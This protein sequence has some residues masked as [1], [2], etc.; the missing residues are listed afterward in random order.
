MK[1]FLIY[2]SSA[3]SGKTY[4]LVK[5]YLKLVLANP[6]DFRHTLAITFTNKAA[7]EM[8]SR[9]IE[10]LS[11]LADG[12]N[13][14]LKKTLTS[15]GVKCN[16]KLTS[17]DVLSRILH[18]Y[19]DFSVST[20]DSFFQKVIRSFAKELKLHL[21][22]TI[23]LDTD[24]VLDKVIDEIFTLIG[25]DAELTK[26][27][28]EFTFQSMDED[29]GW[30]VEK[31]IK[32][33]SG[34]ILKERYWQKKEQAADDIID[35]RNRIKEFI[36]LLKSF[37]YKFENYL[38]K[39][40]NNA[41]EIIKKH[42]LE[43]ED[44]KR[45]NTSIAA[46]FKKLTEKTNYLKASDIKPYEI[47]YK[48]I[49]GSNEWYTKDS[50]KKSVIQAAVDDGLEK[51]LFDIVRYYDSNIKKYISVRI[52]LKTIYTVGIFSDVIEKLKEY[53]D[54]NHVLLISDAGNLLKS[55]INED[56]SPFVYE[57][58]G[59]YYKHYL[60]DEFQ[61][62]STFQ[63]HS[64]LPLVLN[65]LSEQ[66]FSMVVGDVKQS[67]YRWRNG[68]MML[69]LKDIEKDLAHYKELIESKPLDTN[70]R[71]RSNIIEFNNNLFEQAPSLIAGSIESDEANIIT[72][73]YKEANQKAKP[74]HT[75]GYV[76]AE[77]VQ[78][79]KDSDTGTNEIAGNKMIEII[80]KLKDECVNPGDILILARS[81]DEI[82]NIAAL[83]TNA[84]YKVVS[85]ESLL[86]INSPKVKL[87][88]SLFK[89]I[90]DK[91]NRLAIT[92]ALYNYIIINDQN[93]SSDDVFGK[94]E[95]DN[96]LFY[97]LMP[98]EL[99]SR[100]GEKS[101]PKINPNL[102]RQNLYELTESLI[103]IFGLNKKPDLYLTRFLDVIFE[104]TLKYNQDINAFNN[105]WDDNYTKYSISVTGQ[106]DAIK[107]MT[108]HKAKGLESPVVIIPFTSW[109]T[110]LSGNRDNIWVSSNTI[111]FD[112][113][114][115]YLVKAVK[116][117]KESYFADDY[118]FE[119]VMTKLDNLNL[120]YVAF[121][122]A[123]DRLYIISPQKAN[124]SNN[125]N[126]LLAALFENNEWF[127][128]HKTGECIYEF[129]EP[130]K[131]P[132]EKED[133]ETETLKSETL[134][135]VNFHNKIVIK[136]I[137]E[138]I[139]FERA[140]NFYKAYNRGLILHKALSYIKSAADINRS[141]E[142]IKELGLITDNQDEDL[143]AEL[144]KIVT[145]KRIAGWFD[146][147]SE[148]K[149]EQEIIT[150]EGIFRPDRIIIKGSK[151]T[152]VDY[153]T[154]KELTEHKSQMKKYSEIIKHMGYREIESY[155]FY[156]GDL[157]IVRVD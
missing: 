57:K 68:N 150:D 54:E 29:K 139:S 151:I 127:K 70:Y 78:Y 48:I 91:K 7:E 134:T 123:R 137:H 64:L 95:I 77:F 142:K 58:I 83:V 87:L 75:G 156:L 138:N 118:D 62:T 52:L 40:A 41:L 6:E 155:L 17:A 132:S 148:I 34:E 107:V 130:V 101:T 66:N 136:P 97:K 141:A 115:S 105:W 122:R 89:F 25:E 16:I 53:R 38:I 85:D 146:P 152:L 133:I 109:E 19:T 67:I 94:T 120:M 36:E 81:K 4:T 108:I 90:S 18:N 103:R 10:S 154:G 23:E 82:R 8:K 60:I 145:D 21:G 46:Y 80:D 49:S 69:L 129:G 51:C 9:I 121:T 144:N 135:S 43:I 106:I 74:G 26:Y 37:R 55:V 5:E 153:K 61:D 35:N 1:N 131:I 59:S 143:R 47:A 96:G 73:S 114:S 28:E 125:I 93:I 79:E 45:K 65:S 2:R 147:N 3:G 63:W 100:A 110:E 86:L 112:S 99:F 24:I 111:P 42:G 22:Y 102:Y 113:S 32:E 13:P 76:K 116:D 128:S 15:E 88:I 98:S 126:S 14:D 124:R 157:N 72:D 20:I 56:N 31:N 30:K 39:T 71:S 119:Y 84:G 33:L 11:S 44:F 104:Y 140:E 12:T 117:L 50:P 27:I 149:T 92:E